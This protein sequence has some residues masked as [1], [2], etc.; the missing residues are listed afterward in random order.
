M[1]LLKTYALTVKRGGTGGAYVDGRWV[2]NDS[3][4]E[5]TIKTSWQPANQKDLE[6]LEEGKRYSK[7]YKGYPEIKIQTADQHTLQEEDII[8]APDG[9]DY[10]IIHTE[11]WQNGLIN[12][13]KF[14]AVREKEIGEVAEID[15]L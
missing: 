13:Y 14:L 11:D 1:S 6:V 8:V 5:F 3:P 10:Q 15:L 2:A 7:I 12:H 9:F 4:L